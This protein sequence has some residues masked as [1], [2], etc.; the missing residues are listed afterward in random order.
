MKWLISIFYNGE[1]QYTLPQTAS[2][3]QQQ[4]LADDGNRQPDHLDYVVQ[5]EGEAKESKKG[6]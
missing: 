1:Y 6:K 5:S 4:N 2:K 3:E